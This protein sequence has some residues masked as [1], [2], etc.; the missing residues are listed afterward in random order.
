MA[1]DALI[2]EDQKLAV[3]HEGDVI[4]DPWRLGGDGRRLGGDGG[5]LAIDQCRI[6]GKG[7]DFGDGL[8]CP[9]LAEAGGG[10][11]VIESDCRCG[12]NEEWDE[13]LELAP[14]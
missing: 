14:P 3:A 2:F 5:G 1:M 4:A 13:E 11:E 10:E 6:G 8:M 12:E 9:G 7:C